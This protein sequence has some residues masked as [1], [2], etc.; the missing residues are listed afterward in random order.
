MELWPKINVQ[1]I[2]TQCQS[3]LLARRAHALQILSIVELVGDR[4]ALIETLRELGEVNGTLGDVRAQNAYLERA[5][6]ASDEFFGLDHP[7]TELV[8]CSLESALLSSGSN[9]P[10]A[11]MARVEAAAERR[12]QL[13][14][15]QEQADGGP[16]G[17]RSLRDILS[18]EELRDFLM[19]MRTGSNPRAEL[20][21]EHALVARGDEPSGVGNASG[22]AAAAASA[23]MSSSAERQPTGSASRTDSSDGLGD[24]L[25]VMLA[26]TRVELA[27]ANAD[28]VPRSARNDAGSAA[29]GQGLASVGERD[30]R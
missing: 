3:L 14:Q 20:I 10:S 17:A 18:T 30:S 25:T 7:T 22:P 13:Q 4:A 6:A 15:F 1:V 11:L 26:R 24:G 21:F 8:L 29:A 5:L 27:V 19:T 12:R 9:V 2:P 23:H 28:S 16:V